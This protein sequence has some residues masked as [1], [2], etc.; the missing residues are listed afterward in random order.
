MALIFY[1]IELWLLRR[2]RIDNLPQKA[3]WILSERCH[4]KRLR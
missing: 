4:F 1:Q 3:R 2:R